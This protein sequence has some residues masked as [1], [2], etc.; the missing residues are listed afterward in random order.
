[1]WRRLTFLLLIVLPGI[2]ATFAAKAPEWVESLRKMPVPD[3]ARKEAIVVYFE[4]QLIDVSKSTTKS[5]VR[6]AVK[7]LT[8]EGLRH[9]TLLA[10]QRIVEDFT[11]LGAWKIRPDGEVTRYNY[12]DVIQYDA[13]SSYEFS[14]SKIHALNPYGAR[15]GDFIAWE[16]Q[17]KSKPETHK[18]GWRF[19]AGHPTL[20]SRFGIKLPADWKFQSAIQNHEG[21]TPS[22]DEQGYL[23]WEMRNLRPFESEPYSVSIWD[24]V[25]TLRI[26]YGPDSEKT[27]KRDFSSWKSIAEWYANIVEKQTAT[28]PSIAQEVA[29]VIEGSS[30]Q[31]E[32][33]RRI[34]EFTQGVRY[35]NTAIGRSVA[36][37]HLAAEILKN[38]Y[39]DCEDKAV[40]TITML[41]EIG[42]EAY[43]VMAL[44]KGGGSVKIDFPSLTFN[45]AIVAIQAPEETNPPS[46]VTVDGL[47]N[48][49]FFDPT[50]D[51]VGLG[52]LPQR[53]QGTH[54]L[55][56]HPTAGELITIPLLPPEASRRE[57]EILV[58][59]AE[60]GKIDVKT[61]IKYT[62]GYSIWL[63]DY[64]GKVRGEKR[65]QKYLESLRSRFGKVEISKMEVTG[66]EEPGEP[67]VR[68]LEFRIPLPGKDLGTLMTMPT[69]FLLGT[70]APTFNDKERTTPLRMDAGYEESERTIIEIPA[71]WKLASLPTPSSSSSPV[72]EYEL[73]ASEEDG[74]IIVDRRLSILGGTVPAAEYQAVREFFRAV[75]RGDT[76]GIAFE[77]AADDS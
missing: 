29:R 77:K 61:R 64:Y 67:I 54:A 6:E 31:Y 38:R 41:R 36:E 23:V 57:A 19:V 53:L 59:F 33:I 32:K 24:L 55:L 65:Q 16:Y 58:S 45:H 44:T 4:E 43:P 21:L 8:S 72:G 73:T 48:L 28:D 27:T 74:K 63:R 40:L 34:T 25:P 3:W 68:E 56:A 30:T 10:Q 42:I 62:G 13:D 39:G 75:A 11:F 1:M 7:P 5:R 69:Q 35:L 2:T 60:G 22:R 46:T 20:I 26:S 47:G 70:R 49:I 14:M 15:V 12:Q 71:G 52:D 50:D 9:L 66:V 17:L 76:A 37:P 18:L 51:R